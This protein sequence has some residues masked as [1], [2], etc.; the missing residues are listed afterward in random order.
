[1]IAKGFDF[2]NVSLVGIIDADNM[3]NF[4]D[5][6]AHERA[7]QLMSQVSG[8][9]GRKGKQGAVV[10]QT[11]NPDQDI[12]NQVKSHSFSNF[13]N[14]Q[15]NERNIF[16]YPPFSRL[17]IIR[18]KHTDHLILDSISEKFTSMMKESF[19]NRVLGPE[20][21]IISKI[22]N[23]F[24][25]NVLLKVEFGKSFVKAKEIISYILNHMKENKLID[26]CIVQIDVD[27]N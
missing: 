14:L 27:P 21:P 15:L 8:R 5:F 19:N 17:I 16:N 4:P 24:I 11:Y 26:R 25:K 6:R 18:F 23:Y 13:Y 9:A 10:L 22:R 12:I 1:M 3:L 20:Y 2:D 7:F